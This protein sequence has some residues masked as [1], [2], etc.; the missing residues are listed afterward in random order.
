MWHIQLKSWAPFLH[1]L[2]ENMLVTCALQLAESMSGERLLQNL[3]LIMICRCDNITIAPALLK[4][5]EDSMEPLER[6]LWPTM[7]DCDE[8][9]VDLT[10]GQ[11][12][13]RATPI[14]ESADVSLDLYNHADLLSSQNS[15]QH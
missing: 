5:L 6:K 4:Q 3:K 2:R 10:A 11:V 13:Q 1:V 14:T 7:G 8:P 15:G 12:S 9:K